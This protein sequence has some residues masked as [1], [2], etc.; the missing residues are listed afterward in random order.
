MRMKIKQKLL[1]NKKLD[2]KEIS[3]LLSNA[4][5]SD[6]FFTILSKFVL[7]TDEAKNVNT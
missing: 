3:Y 7:I 1:N 4:K 5:N 2:K 6:D